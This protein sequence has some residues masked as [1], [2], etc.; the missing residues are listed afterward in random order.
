VRE[1]LKEIC[2]V[3]A[4]FRGRFQRFGEAV[5][6][7][8]L[9][10]RL[11]SKPVRTLVLTDLTD[12]RDRPLSDHLWFRVGKQFDA[13]NLRPGDRVEFTA[14]VEKYE[15]RR[16]DEYGDGYYIIEDYC[17]KR[18]CKMVKLGVHDEEGKGL[19]FADLKI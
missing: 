16:R 10:G 19:L 13:L 12:D 17:L 1:K 3:R 7:F 14:T 18:P 2:G 8:R 4:R 15:K 9:N 6:R 5:V 11:R